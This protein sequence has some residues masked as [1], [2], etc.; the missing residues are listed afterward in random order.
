MDWSLKSYFT[1]FGSP[2]F[3]IFKQDLAD[4]FEQLD[5]LAQK[6]LEAP[7]FSSG[8]WE[9][10][11]LDYEHM[12]A[13]F[14]HLSSYISCLTAADATNEAYLKEESLLSEMQAT[15]A[16]L[17]DK[18]IRGIG[19]MSEEEFSTLIHRD[20]L[21]EAAFRLKEF[22][23]ES[24]H[25]MSS[26]LEELT[27][28]LGVNGISAWSRL[29]FTT[30]GTLSF[31]YIDPETGETD[32]PMSQLNSLLSNPLRERRLAAYKG[33]VKTFEANQHLYASALNSISGTRHVLNKRR[34][35]GNFLQPSLEQSRIKH[36]TLQALMRA[37]EDRLPFVREVFTFRTKFLKI[38]NPSYADLRAPLPLGE[39]SG[40]TWDEGVELVSNAF[41]TIYPS[42]G[43][44]FDELISKSW[45][46]FTPRMGKRPGGFCTGSLM[47]R[48]SRIFMTYKDTLNDVLTLA[49][50]AG[51]AWHSRIL[52]DARVLCAGYPMTLAE[53]ASTL[54]ERMLT[55]GVLKDTRID[56]LTKLIILDA[57]IEHMLAFLLDIP[58]RFRFEEEV[59]HRRRNGTLSPGEL[60]SLMKDMQRKVFGESLSVGGEDPWFWT[61]KLHFY[62]NQVQFY[63]YPYTFGY[64]LSTA[65]MEQFRQGGTETLNSYER[66][67]ALSGQMSC[68]EV[69]SET[70]AED[71]EDPNFWAGLIDKLQRP[72]GEY[73]TLLQ[74][75]SH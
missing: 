75:L 29:Y 42:L 3:T 18:I 10:F 7:S 36:T 47:T 4:S 59:Y 50:E 12:L 24:K 45:V 56:K 72:F 48:E 33:A 51:H 63:N 19:Q 30:M 44:F 64:L 37:I 6:L 11:L 61:S 69:V 35:I 20:R 70:L 25:R 65:F 46:D 21:S 71:I 60:C 2:V 67:L 14:S 15:A 9:T 17:N 74:E 26:D 62:I 22:R 5:S 40:P 68:E 23:R 39:G 55:E 73:K 27:A 8:D 43:S 1:Q 57:E 28:D 16:K 41:N 53:T 54:A 38:D 49:H 13:N 32:V 31:T 52:K 58:V 34:G 66:F